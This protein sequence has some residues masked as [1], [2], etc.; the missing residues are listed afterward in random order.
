MSTRIYKGFRLKTACLT[1]VLGI[2]EGFRPWVT[3]EADRQFDGF[4]DNV[5]ATGSRAFEAYDL[6]QARRRE[7][8]KTGKRDPEVDTDFSVSLVPADKHLLGICAVKHK[9]A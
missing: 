7:V 1:E 8:E 6:W 5:T 3:A 2:I 4:M 9:L